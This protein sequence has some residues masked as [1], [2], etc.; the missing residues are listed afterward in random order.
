MNP[1]SDLPNAYQIEQVSRSRRPW[2]VRMWS[3][4]LVG[5]AR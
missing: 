3:L 5:G 1:Y 4:A 2:R